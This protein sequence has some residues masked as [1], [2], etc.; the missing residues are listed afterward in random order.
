MCAV[1]WLSF[2]AS[3]VG[4]LGWPLA[5]VAL[6]LI[7]RVELG[8]LIGRISRAKAGPVEVWTEVRDKIA[9]K[10]VVAA[11]PTMAAGS[12]QALGAVVRTAGESLTLS[13]R[14]A[15]K[16]TRGAQFTAD[17]VIAAMKQAATPEELAVRVVEYVSLRTVPGL[18]ALSPE[19]IRRERELFGAILELQTLRASGAQPHDAQRLAE[20]LE[21]IEVFWS[22]PELLSDEA[23]DGTTALVRGVIED[24]AE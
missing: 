21:Q 14:A 23:V 9:D 16:V 8:E 10:V 4:S 22:R 11:S 2:V 12:G 20:A 7:F 18:R 24:M 3:L 17:A 15:A 5:V 19:R 6:A 1:D 13:D